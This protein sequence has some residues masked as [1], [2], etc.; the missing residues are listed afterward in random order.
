MAVVEIK[1]LVKHYGKV[2]A[3]KGVSLSVEKGEIFGLLGRNGAGKTTMVKILLGIVQPTSGF[4]FLLEQPAGAAEARKRVGF[5]P[6]DHRFPD[7]HTGRSVLDFYGTLY[8]MSRSDRLKRIAE[9]LDLVHLTEA[10]DRKIR[11][12]SKGMKQR[13]GLAQAMLHRPDVFFLDEPTDGVDPIGRREI[14]E[15]LVQLKNEGKTIFVNS[16]ILSEVELITSRVAIL[17]EGTMKKQG[18]VQELTKT[19]NLYELK[20]E[21]DPVPSLDAIAKTGASARKVPGG[22][23]VVLPDGMKIGTVIDIL[24]NRGVEIMGVNQK[25]QSLEDIFIETVTGEVVEG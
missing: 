20:V 25:K 16:H 12:Y 8:G 10:A 24:R 5:L 18:S 22:L 19:Q 7:Y 1:S 15:V 2:Q 4:A 13:V 21:G 23:E 9:V 11:T 17:E 3:L 6:E 14:R